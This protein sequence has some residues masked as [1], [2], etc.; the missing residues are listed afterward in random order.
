M[1]L[2]FRQAEAS[3]I[4][5]VL[6]LFLATSA[7]LKKKGMTQ[8]SYWADP[9]DEKIQWVRNG[10]EKGEFYF[11]YD[12]KMEWV[13]MFRLL[14][15]DTIYWDE[16]GLEENV[17]YIHSLVVKPENSGKGIGAHVLKLLAA[18]LKGQG[19]QKLRLD[20]DS[21]NLRL[22]RYYEQQGFE[23]VG[24]KKTPFSVNHLFERIL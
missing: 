10:F 7:E 16:K 2:T 3:R 5:E 9:P 8:W 11:V 18:D 6:N 24:E 14:E 22:T 15:T 19:V 21:S 17:R 20:C 23:R 4:Q 12:E 1:E 13:G